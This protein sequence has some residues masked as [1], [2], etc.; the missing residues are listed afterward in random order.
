MERSELLVESNAV[1]LRSTY[2]YINELD[3]AALYRLL[4]TSLQF[5]ILSLQI[6]FLNLH[7]VVLNIRVRESSQL[8]L[9]LLVFLLESHLSLYRVREEAVSQERLIL[10]SQSLL[11]KRLLD[12]RPVLEDFVILLHHLC[13]GRRISLLSLVISQEL[14]KRSCIEAASL[15]ID[16]WSLLKHRVSTCLQNILE[17]SVCYGKTQLAGFLSHDLVLNVCVPNHILDL[18][19][20]ILREIFL[21]LLHLDDFGV[22]IEQLLKFLYADFLT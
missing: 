13:I 6:A 16:E 19:H 14:L 3:V 22:L 9:A 5:I 2:L 17:L 10:L 8:N 11:T 15:L 4:E 18:I 12:E 1:S 21:S 20:L 7:L